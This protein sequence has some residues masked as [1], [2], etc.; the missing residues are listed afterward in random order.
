MSTDGSRRGLPAVPVERTCCGGRGGGSAAG[1]AVCPPVEPRRAAIAALHPLGDRRRVEAVVPLC[2]GP[3]RRVVEAPGKKTADDRSRRQGR[4]AE[5]SAS[6]PPHVGRRD[7]RGRPGG[8]DRRRRGPGARRSGP[9]VAGED[10]FLGEGGRGRGSE[11]GGGG[12]GRGV[13]SLGLVAGH[14]GTQAQPAARDAPAELEATA[15][16]PGDPGGLAG[17]SRRRLDRLELEAEGGDEEGSEG[18]KQVHL[19]AAPGSDCPDSLPKGPPRKF[20][21]LPLSSS[22]PRD[23]S[24]L[25]PRPARAAAG[26]PTW[27][28]TSGPPPLG[29]PTSFILAA[30]ANRG[31][32]R[33]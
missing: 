13:G 21:S 5:F 28:G 17:S 7:G 22:L 25:P 18:K 4:T 30:L 15:L 24:A 11:V 12:G 27:A 6:P 3:R 16:P 20:L 29:N 2:H 10:L 31:H 19:R 23:E 9:P 33:R 32:P 1:R 26:E 14:P 8:G